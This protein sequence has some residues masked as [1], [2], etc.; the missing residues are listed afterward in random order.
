MLQCSAP[1]YIQSGLSCLCV[2]VD[3]WLGALGC[4]TPSCLCARQAQ[5]QMSNIPW[6]IVTHPLTLTVLYLAGLG[7]A[8][9]TSDPGRLVLLSSRGTRGGWGAGGGGGRSQPLTHNP[10]A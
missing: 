2:L 4:R 10:L 3:V 7:A 8:C 9:Q 6:G 1:E 5:H